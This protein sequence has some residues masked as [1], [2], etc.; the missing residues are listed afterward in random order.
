M[1]YYDYGVC[2]SVILLSVFAP[3][4]LKLCYHRHT[5]IQDAYVLMNW[6]LFIMKCLSQLSPSNIRSC[7]I[8]C[9]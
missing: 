3:Y 8:G 7:K 6:Y 5:H 9:V 2:E 4:I 1:P